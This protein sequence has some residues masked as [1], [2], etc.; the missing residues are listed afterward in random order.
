[1]VGAD[2]ANLINEAA[3]LAARRNGDDVQLGDF[4]AALEK[5]VLG[6]ERGLMLTQDDTAAHRLP[7]GRPRAC[8]ACSPRCG[9]VRKVSIV[10]RGRALGVTLQSPEATGTATRRV[11]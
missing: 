11:T 6:A 10:P 1:M 4:S 8:S 9:S 2:L 3:L 5:I 7:R